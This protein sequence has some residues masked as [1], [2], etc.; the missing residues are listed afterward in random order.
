MG[1]SIIPNSALRLEPSAI[2]DTEPGEPCL[3]I[4]ARIE[5]DEAH[6]ID[7]VHVMVGGRRVVLNTDGSIWAVS[8]DGRDVP[9]SDWLGGLNVGLMHFARVLER[10]TKE[11]GLG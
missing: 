1:S 5:F 4:D 11:A 8:V 2:P 9:G 6:K 3:A 7:S 10:V